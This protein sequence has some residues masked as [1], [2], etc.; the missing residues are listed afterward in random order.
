VGPY[1]PLYATLGLDRSAKGSS[2]AGFARFLALS[3]P[4]SGGDR[5]RTVPF[6]AFASAALPGD[7]LGLVLGRDAVLAGEIVPHFAAFGGA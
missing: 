2:S 1:H 5:L 6:A 4:V 3:S 7:L